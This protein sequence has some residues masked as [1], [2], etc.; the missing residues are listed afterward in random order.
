MINKFMKTNEFNSMFFISILLNKKP[1][2]ICV[3]ILIK[4][5]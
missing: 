4:I 5:S 2:V 1:I 3:M